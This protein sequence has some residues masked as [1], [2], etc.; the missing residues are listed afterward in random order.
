MTPFRKTYLIKC[1]K[2]ESIS[3]EGDIFLYTETNTLSDTYWKGEIVAV[4]TKVTDEDEPLPV[5]TKVVM[6]YGGCSKCKDGG[7]IKVV[8][9]D[10]IYMIRS[11]DEIIGVIEDDD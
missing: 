1:E 7:G 5:G 2:P 10:G 6:T 11:L 4:G 8:M 3:K 9:T